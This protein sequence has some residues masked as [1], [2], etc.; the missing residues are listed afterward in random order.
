M[1]PTKFFSRAKI[2][3]CEIEDKMH[4]Y[5]IFFDWEGLVNTHAVLSGETVNVDWYM[6]V[7]M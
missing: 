6:K 1:G 5:H 7:L 2:T 3:R 4:G